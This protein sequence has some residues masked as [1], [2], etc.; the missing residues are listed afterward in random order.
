MK[1]T[2]LLAATSVV[3]GVAFPLGAGIAHADTT[4]DPCYPSCKPPTVLPADISRQA[5]V[6]LPADTSRSLPFTG[7]DV[8]ELSLIGLG[9]VATGTVLVRRSNRRT[10]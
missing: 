10:A 1:I 7:T 9:A 2:R 6:V 5:P 4:P 3:A 8:I